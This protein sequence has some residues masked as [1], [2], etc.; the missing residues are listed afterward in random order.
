MLDII[1]AGATATMNEIGMRY[2]K[3][4]LN[5]SVLNWSVQQEIKNIHAVFAAIHTTSHV[6]SFAHPEYIAPLRKEVENVIE[7]EGW[8]EL[9]MGKLRKLDSFI[10]ESQCLSAQVIL[11]RVF[12]N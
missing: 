3:L 5:W 9:T 8:N 10:K 7:T 2:G 12:K 11:S 4:L 1:N 6:S